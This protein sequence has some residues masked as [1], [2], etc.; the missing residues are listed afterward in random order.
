MCHFKYL[1]LHCSKQSLKHPNAE[2]SLISAGCI[3]S[4][5]LLDQLLLDLKQDVP[6]A[7]QI[8]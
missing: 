4:L 1:I 2:K 7:S 8:H 3:A 5:E 6:Q